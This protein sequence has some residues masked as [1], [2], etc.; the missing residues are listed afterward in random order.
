MAKKYYCF[1][2]SNCKYE[3]MTKEQI[4]TAIADA[5]GKIDIDPDAAF[6][7]KVK[8][9]NS[10][11]FVTFWVGTQ[12]QYNELKTI[13]S[14]CLYVITDDKTAE[15]LFNRVVEIERIV[16]EKVGPVHNHDAGEI[17]AG[18]LA[19]KRG[20][21]GN[22]T[23]RVTAGQKADTTLGNLA[24]AEGVQ[25]TASGN[26]S[27]AEGNQTEA[28]GMNSHAEGF[29]AKAT[30]IHS[31]AE[32]W[33]TQANGEA[34]HAE[35]Y[36][37]EARGQVSHAEGWESVAMGTASHAEG[38]MCDTNGS[39]SHAGGHRAGAYGQAAF[40]HGYF[41]SA[42]GDNQFVIGHYNKTSTYG[43]IEG[44]ENAN[45]DYIDQLIVGNGYA[46]QNS[47]SLRLRGNGQLFIANSLNNGGADYAEYF[48]WADGNP[49]NEDRRGL[50]VTL[51]GDKIKVATEGDYI[52]GIVSGQ[53]CIIGNSDIDWQGRFLTDEYG[54]IIR[55]SYTYEVEHIDAATGETV[56][57]YRTGTKPKQ[58][59]DYDP[60]QPYIQRADRKE[61]AAVGMVGVL[62]VR[63][64]G[65]CKVNSYCKVAADGT[66]TASTSA[67]TGYR[68]IS[69]VNDH[70]VKVIVK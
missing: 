42:A 49:N 23:G 12:A 46:G 57:E 41:V 24:T 65:S 10:G 48:E 20:G 17:V 67:K 58:N 33:E 30:A 6:I 51:D 45:T 39:A 53:P 21:T 54:T 37:S 66:A 9:G 59:P 4:L 62:A 68:V 7:T 34:G 36:K 44:D 52:L 64:D 3:T 1:C 50:F 31:H 5:T 32:G 16:G 15:Q 63:D 38:M 60:N 35:G 47:N 13:E 14:S 56:V 69:R 55:E 2:G 8:E 22:T 61:W 70:I 19:V 40:A 43:S 28:T 25:T 27:H 18:V 26:F 29:K 11:G